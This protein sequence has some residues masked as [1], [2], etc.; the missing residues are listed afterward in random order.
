MRVWDGIFCVLTFSHDLRQR[1]VTAIESG[2]YT[3]S[4]AAE[5]YTVSESFVWKLLRRYRLSGSCAALPHGGGRPRTLAAVSAPLRAAVQQ[6]PEATLDEL[7]VQMAAHQLTVSPSMMCRELHVRGL[8]RKKNLHDER[9]DSPPVQAQRHALVQQL[10]SWSW[11]HLK[12]LDEMRL[13]LGL[14]R[15]YGRAPRGQRVTEAVPQRPKPTLTHLASLS[16]QGLETA[17]TFEGALTGEL[18]KHYTTEVLAPSLQSGDMVL[19]DNLAAHKVAGIQEAIEARGARVVYLPPDSPD[20]NPIEQC[21]SKLKTA[22]RAAKA[23]T[24]ADLEQ[25]LEQALRTISLHDIRAWF[26]HCGYPV[27][28]LGN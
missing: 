14:T 9:R 25:A 28:S 22:L 4:E 21:W 18:F 3:K 10:S 20:V 19:L 2:L 7:C 26:T 1:I 13:S 17:V 11:T 5:V 8:P 24:L 23:R 27:H 16:L 15:L 6:A 12:V